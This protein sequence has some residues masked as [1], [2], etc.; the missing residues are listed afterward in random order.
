MKKQYNLAIYL[1]QNA[2][3]GTMPISIAILRF[4]ADPPSVSILLIPLQCFLLIFSF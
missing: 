2:I 4:Y 1:C 3:E